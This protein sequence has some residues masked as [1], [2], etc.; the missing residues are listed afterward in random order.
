MDR[1]SIYR[2]SR[3]APQIMSFLALTVCAIG[4]AVV[5]REHAHQH[6][7]FLAHIYQLIMVAQILCGGPRPYRDPSLL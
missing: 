7:G 6:G 5:W 4:W 2:F 3:L 1:A